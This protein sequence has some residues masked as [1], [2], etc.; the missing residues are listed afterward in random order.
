MNIIKGRYVAQLEVDFEF[1]DGDLRADIDK[2]RSDIIN[3]TVNNIVKEEL[4]E[5]FGDEGITLT[6]TQTYGDAYLVNDDQKE[7]E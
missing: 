5:F 1:K 7:G 6:L 2:V 3:G 4:E